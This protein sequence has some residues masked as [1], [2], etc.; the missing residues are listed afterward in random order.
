VNRAHSLFR[1]LWLLPLVLSC[2]SIE[3]RQSYASIS[4]AAYIDQY[5]IDMMPIR[6]QDTFIKTCDRYSIRPTLAAAMGWHE[7]HMKAYM[8][9]DRLNADGTVDRGLYQLNSGMTSVFKRQLW[10]NERFEPFNSRQNMVTA[11]WYL[12]NRLNGPAHGDE[13]MALRLY[14]AGPKALR[15][16]SISG[17]EY[18][19]GVLSIEKQ[20]I[21]KAKT[22]Y[23]ERFLP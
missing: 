13:L 23:Y 21:D 15:R 3:T 8:V 19:A 7:S 22:L 5:V 4:E 16:G 18:A 17:L 6:D 11:L 12:R 14:N 10:P 20:I 2:S 9:A 1:L